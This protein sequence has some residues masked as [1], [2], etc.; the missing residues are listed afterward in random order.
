[1]E[2]ASKELSKVAQKELKM[3]NDRKA[4]KDINYSDGGIT[5]RKKSQLN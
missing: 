2:D 1:M 3:T 4:D 5:P